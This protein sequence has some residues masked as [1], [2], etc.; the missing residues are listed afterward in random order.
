MSKIPSRARVLARFRSSIAIVLAALCLTPDPALADGNFVKGV[1]IGK[2]DHGA[3]L[4]GVDVQ[5]ETTVDGRPC[6]LQRTRTGK[7]GRFRSRLDP[8]CPFLR[9]RFSKA[10]YLDAIVDVNNSAADNDVGAVELQ[11]SFSIHAGRAP[12]MSGRR[13]FA[14]IAIVATVAVTTV[15]AILAAKH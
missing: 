4:D 15:A 7:K 1:V 3:P 14:V 10:G 13:T 12:I 11:P 6:L 8:V 5:S 2:N 9:L